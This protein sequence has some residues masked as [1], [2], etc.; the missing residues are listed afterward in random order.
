MWR[1]ALS[2]GSTGMPIAPS[3]IATKVKRHILS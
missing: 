2:N 3:K 1:H